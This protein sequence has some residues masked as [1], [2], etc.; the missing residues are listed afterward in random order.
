[1]QDLTP[2]AWLL[3]PPKASAQILPLP[4]CG[5]LP[6]C[7]S[8]IVNVIRLVAIPEI[9]RLL[10]LYIAGLAAIFV[11]IGG[12]RYLLSF[13]R[14]EQHTKAAK[15][16]LWA[17][18]GL[19]VALTSQRLVVMVVSEIYVPSATSWEN[20]VT[21]FLQSSIR[22]ITLLL[23][24]AFLIVILISGM[25]MVTASGRDEEITKS[26]K[27]IL[28]AIGGIVIIN[29]AAVMVKAVKNIIF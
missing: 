23:N 11:I 29:V 6:G 14:E 15:S 25:R 17:L 20:I 5:A 24:A 22:I 12:A 2:L 19:I 13:G 3:L 27:M 8:P 7:G 18:I 16:I 26:R 1:M 4:P 28:Y 9:A 10:L 21:A